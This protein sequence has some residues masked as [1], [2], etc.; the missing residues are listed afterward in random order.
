[1][2]FFDG[3]CYN[4][5]LKI[6]TPEDDMT[7]DAGDPISCKVAVLMELDNGRKLVQFVTGTGPLGF[8]GNEID[9]VT[10][11]K[12]AILPINR[13][14]PVRDMGTDPKEIYRRS[15][16]G[17]GILDGAE[18]FC[19][20]GAKD[21]KSSDGI[22]CIS[23]YEKGHKKMVYSISMKVTHVEKKFFIPDAQ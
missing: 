17:E 8:S 3:K 20:F 6:G 2:W 11:D 5:R 15:S 13:I 22:S 9:K 23:K 16:R 21:I 7:K 18:G 14:L 4:S 1:M 10:N 12:M 19:F